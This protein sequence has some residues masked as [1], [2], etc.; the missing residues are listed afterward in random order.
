ME[1]TS[2][3]SYNIFINLSSNASG[4]ILNINKGQAIF[5]HNTVEYVV[6]SS[7][8]GCL[9]VKD[10]VSF[11]L[12][13]N[14]FKSCK[15]EGENNQYS[16]V[17]YCTSEKINIEQF[18]AFLCTPYASQQT[19]SLIRL[20]NTD[21]TLN[22]Y[23]S[24]NCYGKMGASGFSLGVIKRNVVFTYVNVIDSCDHNSIEFHS[25]QNI[26]T[27][28]NSNILNATKN[29]NIVINNNC[30]VYFINCVFGDCN[31]FANNPA[32]L[33]FEDCVIYKETQGISISN[34]NKQT[35]I[36]FQLK[37]DLKSKGIETCSRHLNTINKL[38][39]NAIIL[40]R[41]WN[42]IEWFNNKFNWFVFILIIK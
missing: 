4:T 2:L 8:P 9:L 23:N 11:S 22:Y 3:I 15:G 12:I 39:I 31:K 26:V 18:S 13:Q 27:L 5:S 28:Q 40:I 7:H 33:H 35:S 36:D 25:T 21:V 19:D 42:I 30:D 10:E 29:T 17:L 34:I 24:S 14:Y 38:I 1:T 16:H 37:L 20:E 6:S 32:K 41:Y